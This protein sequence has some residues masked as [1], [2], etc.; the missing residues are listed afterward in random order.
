MQHGYQFNFATTC[1]HHFLATSRSCG[2]FQQ[3][4]LILLIKALPSLDK[5]GSPTVDGLLTLLEALLTL[6]EAVDDAG[7]FTETI[8][9]LVWV[10]EG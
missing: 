7:G 1:V 2:I 4:L 10:V 6:L 5:F 3:L 8:I 9:L